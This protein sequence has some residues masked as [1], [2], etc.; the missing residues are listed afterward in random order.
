MA[1]AHRH[2]C[3]GIDRHVTSLTHLPSSLSVFSIGQTQ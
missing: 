3:K 2:L 1:T